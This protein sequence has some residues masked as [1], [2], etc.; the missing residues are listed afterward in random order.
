[1]KFRHLPS[2]KKALLSSCALMLLSAQSLLAADKVTLD[3]RLPS[4]TFIYISAPNAEEMQEKYKQT[5]FYQLLQEEQVKEFCAQIT[6]KINV[7]I[8]EELNMTVE[9]LMSILSGEVSLAVFKPS[10]QP[11][12]V[13]LSVDFG[14]SRDKVDALIEKAVTE[15]EKEGSE[16]VE[17]EYAGA[18]LNIV[19]ITGANPMIPVE[20][21]VVFVIKDTTFM[22]SNSANAVKD[23]LDNWEGRET[24]SFKSSPVY[25]QVQTECI[26]GDGESVFNFFI[27]PISLFNAAAQS[28]GPQGMQMQMGIAMMQP[29]GI[30]N[31][32]GIGS[33]SEIMVGDYESISR[34]L[35]YTESEPTG[36]LKVFNFPATQQ[37]PADWV[38][39][40]VVSFQAFNWD[41]QSA[42]D[43]IATIIDSFQGPGITEQM[44]EGLAQQPNGPGV[45]IKKDLIDQLSGDIQLFTKAGEGEGVESMQALMLLGAEVN[46]ENGMKDVLTR[47]ADSPGFPG[48]ARDFQGSTIY[49]MLNPDPNAPTIAFTVAKGYFFFTTEVELLEQVIRGISTNESLVESEIY[50]KLAEHFPAETSV[51]GFSDPRTQ[52]K[53]VYENFQSGEL[54]ALIPDIDFTLL[55]EYEVIEKYF[56]TAASYT[57]P[58]EHGAMM[59]QFQLKD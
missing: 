16:I 53:P 12:A 46:D 59:V 35:F 40:D 13:V 3:E 29:L 5:K 49:E 41:A 47:V 17:E 25:S 37:K 9:D 42:Y 58:V 48:E 10:E 30:A 22:I 44:V 6:D 4:D 33:C 26:S 51:I 52:L 20:Q 24:S 8:E 55:P 31:L 21:R 14:E 56:G 18:T 50:K 39:A 43:A 45:H 32:K 27:D 36:L 15:S 19:E 23:I 57:V 34:T 28:A 2:L 7:T 54:G 1:M 38:P 11:L